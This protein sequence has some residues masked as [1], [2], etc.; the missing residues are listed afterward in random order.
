RGAIAIARGQGGQRGLGLGARTG[1]EGKPLISL[2]RHCQ[3]WNAGFD[4]R[5]TVMERVVFVYTTF[6]GVV[7]AEAA[8]KVIVERRLAACANIVPGMIS[9]YWWQ[10]KLERA[11]EAV[12]LLKTRA[13]LAEDVRSAIRELHS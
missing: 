1:H 9:H 7:E 11:E 12:M 10:G 3:P 2:L 5:E 6:P 4:Q 13:S 8:A